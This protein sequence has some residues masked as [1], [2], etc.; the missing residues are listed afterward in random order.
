MEIL[1]ERNFRSEK[2]S[3]CLFLSENPGKKKVIYMKFDK[4]N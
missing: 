3:V 1:L 2:Y 4:L